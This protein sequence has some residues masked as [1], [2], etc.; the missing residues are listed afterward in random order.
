M[1]QNFIN[2]NEEHQ[3]QAPLFNNVPE[4]QPVKAKEV[5]ERLQADLVDLTGL[6][7]KVQFVLVVLDVMSRFMWL[8]PLYSKSAGE[9]MR[10]L[11]SI[12]LTFGNPR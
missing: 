8:R 1:I 12:W 7:H 10:N 4:L 6:K 5:M 3:K 2:Q 9:V 11:K